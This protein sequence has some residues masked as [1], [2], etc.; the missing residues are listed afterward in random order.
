MNAKANLPE[1]NT[2]TAELV[3]DAY[4]AVTLSIEALG[5]VSALFTCIF[6][7][8]Q[9]LHVKRLASIGQEIVDGRL[10]CLEGVVSDFR[11]GQVQALDSA[12]VAQ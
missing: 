3:R 7:E 8:A 12:G 1:S 9:S 6:K 2:E 4:D 11:A 5:D 10:A